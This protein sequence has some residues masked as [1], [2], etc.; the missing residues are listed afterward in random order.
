[1]KRGIEI[2][3]LAVFFLLT[4][5]ICHSQTSDRDFIVQKVRINFIPH[6]NTPP[7]EIIHIPVSRVLN[8][9]GFVF[10][11]TDENG[12]PICAKFLKHL[13]RPVG[14][15]TDDGQPLLQQIIANVLRITNDSVVVNIY[16][17]DQPLN[18]YAKANYLG[19]DYP[20][21]YV[22]PAAWRGDSDPGTREHP[23]PGTN[24]TGYIEFGENFAS[25]NG[26]TE[27]R[28]TFVHEVTHTQD[29]SNKRSHIWGRFR[30]G[31]DGDHYGF[32]L[33]PNISDAFGEGMANSMTYVYSRT[34]RDQVENWFGNNDYC[35]IETPPSDEMIRTNHLPAKDQWIYTQI[36]NND[37]PG[38][39]FIPSGSR[40]RGYRGYRLYELPGRFLM[41]NEQIIGMIGSEYA[42]RIGKPKYFQAIRSGNGRMFRVSTNAL[43]RWFEALSETAIPDGLSMTIITTT[44]RTEMPYLF[45]FAL[46]DYFT[47]YKSS[48]KEEFGELF[49]AGISQQW[50]DLY[51]NVGKRIV[52]RVRPL[53]I[54]NDEPSIIN[55]SAD[56]DAIATALG[57][58]H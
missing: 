14:S 43:A 42:R 44:T 31:T 2:T 23:N 13:L 6:P 33:V 36:S 53:W 16:K 24:H 30:Y 29:F 49:G 9:G 15:G 26:I 19:T 18:A 38:R 25:E 57:I 45:A 5:H 11:T 54:I 12:M 51:W 1:M 35:I 21:E 47:F 40:Y 52:R 4:Q 27:I 34:T 17:D 37:P 55:V 56:L 39:G 46:A 28:R 7:H 48:T 50:I 10:G 20:D 32:E 3:C 22:W 8:A 41:Q 58:G